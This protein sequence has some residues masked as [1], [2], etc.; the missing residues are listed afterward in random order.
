MPK[1]Q[2]AGGQRLSER[3]PQQRSYSSDCYI[4]PYT[5]PQIHKS[6]YSMSSSL[7][8]PDPALA[9]AADATDGVDTEPVP[10]RTRQKRKKAW[11]AR[12]RTGCLTCRA[13][14]V[15]C[16]EEKPSCRRCTR[17]GHFCRGY[18]FLSS[19]HGRLKHSASGNA[20]FSGH[21]YAYEQLSSA[22]SVS[23][24]MLIEAE[25]PD[26][27]LMQAY[28]YL[29]NA[30][31]L[32]AVEDRIP[33]YVISAAIGAQLSKL[34]KNIGRLLRPGEERHLAPLW[35]KYSRYL[36][37]IVEIANICMRGK[38]YR[39]QDRSFSAIYYL[40]QLEVGIRSSLWLSHLKGAVAYA[41]HIGGPDAVAK[42]PAS[43]SVWFCHI[44]SATIVGNTMVPIS[45]QILDH[46]SYSNMQLRAILSARFDEATTL[47]IEV[48]IFLV[49]IT[50]IRHD[51]AVGAGTPAVIST[52]RLLYAEL[53]L[54]ES[55][56]WAGTTLRNGSIHFEFLGLIYKI[57]S[58]LYAILTLPSWVTAP[59]SSLHPDAS[60]GNGGPYKSL[61]QMNQDL[62]F[63]LLR[64]AD[65]TIG[66][67]LFEW[68]LVVAGVAAQH[69]PIEDQEFVTSSLSGASRCPAAS[70]AILLCRQK[71]HD[72]WR[73]G[74]GG[75]DDCFDEP[76]A[77]W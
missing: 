64:E 22:Q 75:W 37:E 10:L 26:W 17:G 7:L 14:H 70:N 23:T 5:F 51:L 25:P 15:K 73:R 74:K 62:L 35:A 12:A 77:C 31:P 42:L 30:P 49:R 71:L 18:D 6:A 36:L 72:F 46:A 24:R 28:R 57:A 56:T 63:K 3:W 27:D 11:A 32:R 67:S 29:P 50:K 19:Y 20:G 69:G 66:H 2:E 40:M 47:P 65:P 60:C 39:G 41:K 1:D 9:V 48:L 21:T 13:R 43:T 61:R 53:E 8:R 38:K 16:G 59:W 55:F 68:V 45:E 52:V 58:Q 44:L 33:A 76:V 4:Q 54:T 34:S